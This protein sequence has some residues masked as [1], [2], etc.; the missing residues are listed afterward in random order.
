MKTA[1]RNRLIYFAGVWMVVALGVASRKYASSLP[2]FV[3]AYVGDALWALMVFLGMGFIF[4]RRSTN[5]IAMVSLGFCWVIELSQ[6][7]H[8]PWI[9]DLRHTRIGGLI[10]GFGF[11]W[12][13]L[14]SYFVGISTGWLI[15]ERATRMNKL[16]R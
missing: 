11:L 1:K 8:A 6:L 9:D 7:Y 12:S 4:A 15:E 10:L 2:Q 14:V 16:R 5:W 13:D 3:G